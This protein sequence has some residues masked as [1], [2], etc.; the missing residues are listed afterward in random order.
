MRDDALPTI[1]DDEARKRA[2]ELL[3]RTDRRRYFR[4][5]AMQREYLAI[6]SRE[7]DRRNTVGQR[8]EANPDPMPSLPAPD[9]PPQIAAGE[10][11]PLPRPRQANMYEKRF[12]GTAL[13]GTY[14]LVKSA[15]EK[16]GISPG[17]A[18]SV[19]AQETGNGR[20]V[21][22]NNPAGLMD[23]ANPSSKLEF[24]TIDEGIE[25]SVRTIARNFN[26]AGSDMKRLADIYAPI[27]A[28]ND[29]NDRNQY[30]L[31]N[32]D[33]FLGYFGKP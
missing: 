12:S 24:K 20:N 10:P 8:R 25:K 15:A 33:W 13:A 19:M 27:G 5:E 22:Y 32:V 3:M 21:Q 2:I 4:D 16:Y 26:R 29:P 28:K 14:D 30:W 31:K 1:E 9:A 7:E 11:V 23:P 6:L 17:L 18:A